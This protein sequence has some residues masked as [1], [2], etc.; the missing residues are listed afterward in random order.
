[1]YTLHAVNLNV[2]HP[3]LIILHLCPSHTHCA[4]LVL[5]AVV[6]FSLQEGPNFTMQVPMYTLQAVNLNVEHPRIIIRQL[7]PSHCT[8]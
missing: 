7:C 5:Q 4:T 6:K 2:E 1:M 3:T 8:F